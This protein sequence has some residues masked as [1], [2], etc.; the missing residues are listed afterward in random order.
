[1]L[2]RGLRKPNPCVEI[3]N[4]GKRS[5]MLDLASADGQETMR[6]LV[7]TADVFLTSYLPGPRRKLGTG[8]APEAGQ[9]TEEVK[10]SLGYGWD[11]ITA[12]RDKGALGWQARPGH[13][14]A[15][16]VISPKPNE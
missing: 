6:R 5:I 3:P 8:P 1:M 2:N 7:C 13:D 12:Y 16:G 10:L 4:R 14:P 15:G 11:E 9:H